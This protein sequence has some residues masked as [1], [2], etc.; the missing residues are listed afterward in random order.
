MKDKVV[1]VC[2]YNNSSYESDFKLK[3]NIRDCFIIFL[4]RKKKVGNMI[5]YVFGNV[6]K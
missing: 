2:I 1:Y 4:N 5:Y 3:L 6:V